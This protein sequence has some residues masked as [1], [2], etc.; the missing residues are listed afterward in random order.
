MHRMLTARSGQRWVLGFMT[1]A[2]L[3]AAA[4]AQAKEAT[5]KILHA[6]T[7]DEGYVVE[8]PLVAGADGI[9]YGTARF[10]GAFDSGTV[11]RLLPDH[12]VEVV[13]DFAGGTED[14]DDPQ[15]LVRGQDGNLYGLTRLGGKL[16]CGT[17]YRLSPDRQVTL[18][19][20]FSTA[21]DACQPHKTLLASKDGHFYGISYLGN[22]RVFRM[23]AEGKVSV[24][25][26]FMGGEHGGGPWGRLIEGK[27]GQL[28]GTTR[29]GGLYGY[30]TVFRMS[31]QD[32]TVTTLHHFDGKDG[33]N[34]ISGLTEGPDGRYYGVA[35]AK[36]SSPHAR[37]T[38]YRV[39]AEGR[40]R[41]VHD[42]LPP[43]INGKHPFRELL[44]GRDGAFYGTT[45]TGGK[46]KVGTI[47]RFTTD[48]SFSV[49]HS[50]HWTREEGNFPV[51]ELVEA[52][53]GDFLGATLTGSNIASTL[54]RVR[55]LGP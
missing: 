34:P 42:F 9:Y 54:Y 35:T 14:G 37:G 17:A 53:D 51:N 45:D 21:K 40:F 8:G 15:G 20:S 38:I 12:S 2:A 46:E 41:I 25:H 22:G 4:A 28:Y 44:L 43:K 3:W 48:G 5:F 11:F 7:L 13:H 1:A 31:R 39:D 50:L 29:Y 30:G 19:H 47:F 24:L 27:D 18:L 23:T 49:L 55:Y 26:I 16:D 52:A 33:A 6:M 36:R 32:G 10:Y